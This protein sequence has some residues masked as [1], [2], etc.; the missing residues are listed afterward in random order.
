[1]RLSLGQLTRN[2]EIL[3]GAYLLEAL[4]PQLARAAQ[5]GQYCMLRCCDPLLRRPF[6]IAETEPE[7]GLCRFLVYA[8]GRGS[9]WLT[10]LQAGMQL[11]ILGPLGH[12]WTIRPETRNLLLI[13]EEP[14]LAA[15]IALARSAIERELA[16]TLLHRVESVERSY[17]PALLPPEVEY[18]IF[19]EQEKPEQ[20]AARLNEYL[21]WADAACCSVAERTI[22]ALLQSAARWREKHFA[23]VAFCKPLICASGACLSC[24]IELRQGS[25]LICHDG[26]IF[27]LRDLLLQP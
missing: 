19:A 27:A 1:M 17:P 14:G 9:S 13:G 3:P 4:A 16:V 25:R 8:R 5:P 21:S 23:Q 10:R 6:F 22:E 2:S 18:Q 11:D 20:F 15:V 26:P 12:G 24:Q 7:Q